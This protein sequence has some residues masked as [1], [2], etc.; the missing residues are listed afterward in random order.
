MTTKPIYIH[1][2]SV[3]INGTNGNDNK[4]FSIGSAFTSRGL[5][6]NEM[7]T[8][9]VLLQLFVVGNDA[10]MDDDKLWERQQ[11][12]KDYRSYVPAAPLGQQC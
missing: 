10:V 3:I 8:Y 12:W 1:N 4:A 2:N 11:E 7:I 9:Q 5:F 6:S